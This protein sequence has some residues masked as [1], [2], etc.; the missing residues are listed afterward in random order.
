MSVYE[1]ITDRIIK[2]LETGAV[3]WRKP[4]RGTGSEPASL[5]SRKA[6]RGVNAFTLSC[7]S[8]PTPYWLTFR[9]CMA[10][11]GHVRKGEHGWPVIFWKFW[12]EEQPKD[13]A[14][15]RPPLLRYYTV[16]N[17]AQCD[18]IPADKLPAAPALQPRAFQPIAACEAVVAGLPA[19][20]P[21]MRHGFAGAFYRPADDLVAMPD[22]G[23]FESAEAYYATLFH[24][25]AHGTG[26]ASRLNRPA[27]TSTIRF[28][29]PTYSKEELVAEMGAAFVCGHC[30]IDSAP[31]TE[32]HAAYVASWLAR[33]KEDSRLVVMAAAAAQKAADWILGR[34]E[35]TGATAPA[36]AAGEL[37]ISI[38]M[39]PVRRPRLQ[40]TIHQVATH[41][42][43]CHRETC[44]H[45]NAIR[46]EAW[47][48]MTCVGCWP[49]WRHGFYVR[50][51][52][53]FS[54][55]DRTN[56]RGFD[57]LAAGMAEQ[58]PELNRDG[59]PAAALFEL[60][61]SP[62]RRMPSHE[63]L[64][65]EAQRFLDRQPVAVVTDNGSF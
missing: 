36:A 22:R 39:A 51:P 23:D 59:D 28:G 65:V 62:Y 50:W 64:I 48:R 1:V 56:I 46:R 61:Q 17:V 38:P 8:Y 35:A 2:Q 12:D 20:R 43:Q 14:K 27:I 49:F 63:E 60:L 31:L 19:N 18:G 5:I 44:Q 30:G 41:L 58:F 54:T 16:F 10:L 33:L 11:G 55:G 53:A 45:A 29:S 3:P 57:V 4:W 40:A 15:K 32:Q 6:Y 25:L 52:K 37:R 47:E 42:R 9:Q 34:I 24:E 26:H 7:S 21:A 13:A